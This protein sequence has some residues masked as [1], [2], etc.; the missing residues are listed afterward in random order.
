MIT[1]SVLYANSDDASFD[2]DYY[3][4]KHM[5]MVQAKLGS[6][7]LDSQAEQGLA[8]GT[9]GEKPPYVA[10]CHLHFDSVEAFQ[11]AFAPHAEEIL[12][13]VANY[14]NIEPTFQISEI[15]PI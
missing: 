10:L 14:T 1:V 12:A 8:S 6:A 15:K 2:I 5:P 9:P 7:L 3:V 11:G 4:T 13:D